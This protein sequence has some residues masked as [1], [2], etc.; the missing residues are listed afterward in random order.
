MCSTFSKTGEGRTVNAK[1]TVNG[2][3]CVKCLYEQ[4]HDKVTET[5]HYTVLPFYQ[6]DR[7]YTWHLT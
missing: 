2:L 4:K 3:F 6:G 1:R 5:T 7:I